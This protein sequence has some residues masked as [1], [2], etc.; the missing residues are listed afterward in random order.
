[1]VFVL[2]AMGLCFLLLSALWYMSLRDFLMGGTD[3]GKKP[4]LAL[5]GRACS[6]KL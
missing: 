3:G 1:M 4:G 6:V 2:A 5:V